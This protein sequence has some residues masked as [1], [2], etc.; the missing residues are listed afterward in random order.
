MDIP[1]D[2]LTKIEHFCAYQERCESDVRKKLGTLTVSVSQTDEIVKILIDNRFIDEN[3]YADNFIRSK[4][5]S[6]QWGKNKIRQALRA[7]GLDN[8]VVELHLAD[9][10]ENKYRNLIRQTSEK[11][12]RMHKSDAQSQSKLF[13][14]LLSKGFTMEDIYIINKD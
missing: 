7:K 3:R 13:Q 10:D 9:I 2:V 8:K 1:A 5:H 6:N 11:W 4:M 14:Y 12:I